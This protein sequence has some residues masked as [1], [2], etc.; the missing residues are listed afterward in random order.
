MSNSVHRQTCAAWTV[1]LK[2]P[3][4]IL[5]LLSLFS[6]VAAVFFALCGFMPNGGQQSNAP[7][8]T[9]TGKALRDTDDIRRYFNSGETDKSI[10]GL[11]FTASGRIESA[12][13]TLRSVQDK[14]RG[15]RLWN[16]SRSQ[17]HGRCFCS[18]QMC[19]GYVL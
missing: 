18:F 10:V 12:D 6:L 19:N 7:K 3:L 1:F 9:G 8:Y 15:N 2:R 4:A 17:T 5:I 11:D 14:S 13:L 16:R